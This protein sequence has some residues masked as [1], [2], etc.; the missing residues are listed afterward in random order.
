MKRRIY[1][2]VTI[3]MLAIVSLTACG[4]SANKSDNAAAEFAEFTA[5]PGYNYLYYANKTKVIYYMFSTHEA[6][7]NQGYGYG[8]FGEYV[9]EKGHHCRYIDGKIVDIINDTNN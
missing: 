7:G 8:Y 6:A 3:V 2:F 4:T 1:I 9:S 5:I